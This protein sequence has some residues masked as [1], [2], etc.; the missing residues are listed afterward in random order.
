MTLTL[1]TICSMFD[2]YYIANHKADLNKTY[3]ASSELIYSDGTYRHHVDKEG[4]I[5]ITEVSD[6]NYLIYIDQCGDIC[7][8]VYENIIEVKYKDIVDS[9]NTLREQTKMHKHTINNHDVCAIKE[10][11]LTELYEK[12]PKREEDPILVNAPAEIVNINSFTCSECGSTSFEAQ[13]KQNGKFKYIC[14]NCKTKYILIPSKY[15]I[16]KS[17]TI[18]NDLSKNGVAAS[19][20]INTNEDDEEDEDEG[21]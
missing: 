10:E 16:I 19:Y 3:L 13:R 17:K 2:N 4:Y 12:E 8:W 1:P 6:A 18:S 20:A 7:L 15:Y 14:M 5:V 11:H 21:T 9:L